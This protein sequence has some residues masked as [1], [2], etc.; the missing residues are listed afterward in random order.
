MPDT[1]LSLAIAVAFVLPGFIT[2]DLAESRRATKA[3]RSDLELV[4]RGFVY[5]LIIQGAVSAT[6]WTQT[7]VND[8]SP[9]D[10]WKH[11]IGELVSFGLVVGILIPTLI[12]LSLSWWLRGAEFAGQLKPWHYALG[13]RDFRQAWDYVFGRQKGTYLL[14]TVA[15]ES[16]TRHFLAK[17]GPAS[18]ASQAP[19][20][21]QEIYV[22]EVWPADIDGIVDAAVLTREPTRGMWINSDK[23][24]RLE[25]L[26]LPNADPAD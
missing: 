18:W 16:G 21:P 9:K 1:L 17:Y 12:G 3:A 8:V 6:G 15:E 11:H 23:I 14:F 4:L 26:H 20:Q 25:V 7:I 2:A 5:A 19:T 10:A 13:G 22:E 24:E